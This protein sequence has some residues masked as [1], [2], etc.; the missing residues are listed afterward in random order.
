MLTTDWCRGRIGTNV[1]TRNLTSL[2]R[3]CAQGRFSGRLTSKADEKRLVIE[4]RKLG[5]LLGGVI[6]CAMPTFG[7][8]IR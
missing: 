3:W 8:Q 4:C 2:L 5:P 1:I 7:P 6:K